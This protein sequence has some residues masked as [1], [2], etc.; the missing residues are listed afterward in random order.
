MSRVSPFFV[1]VMFFVA[2]CCSVTAAQA[3]PIRVTSGLV[4]IGSAGPGPLG[5][6]W[7]AD[8]LDITGNHGLVLE[9]S[10]EDQFNFVEFVDLPAVGPGP[11]DFSTVLHAED[12][13]GGELNGSFVGVLA[14]FTMSFFASPVALTC[15]DPA[16]E[17]LTQLCTG[18]APFKFDADLTFNSFG[19]SPFTRHLVGVGTLEASLVR[20]LAFGGAPFEGGRVF[21][22]FEASATPEPASLSLLMTGAIMTVAGVFRRRGGS[23]DTT[24]SEPGL[25]RDRKT[26][27]DLERSRS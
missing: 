24:Q 14:P 26:F 5:S 23:R 1:P 16:G 10:F 9:S 19:G 6:P 13:V 21:Y 7:A 15:V 3:D 17:F 25:S 12:S 11:A 2:W 27:P 4:R 20:G 18:V 8:V 22:H